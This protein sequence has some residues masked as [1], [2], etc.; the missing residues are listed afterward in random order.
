MHILINEAGGQEQHQW[1]SPQI[2]V[3]P[4]LTFQV[5]S[6]CDGCQ[7]QQFGRLGEVVD[8]AAPRL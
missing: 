1:F 6:Y 8:I 5:A 3:L 2:L 7:P 4:V